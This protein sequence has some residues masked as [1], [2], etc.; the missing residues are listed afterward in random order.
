M[1]LLHAPLVVVLLVGW[2]GR[3]SGLNMG[4]KTR[5]EGQVHGA[6]RSPHLGLV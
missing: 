6:G 5:Q 1:T 4:T 3:H 2:P